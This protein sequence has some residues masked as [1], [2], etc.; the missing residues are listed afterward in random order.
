[1]EVIFGPLADKKK[2]QVLF[3]IVQDMFSK[4]FNLTS[5]WRL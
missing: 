1:L 5:H 2:S 4:F 3:L